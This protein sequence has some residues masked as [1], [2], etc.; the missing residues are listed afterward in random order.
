MKLLT[1]TFVLSAVI[2]GAFAL[3]G[4]A[5]SH[6][7]QTAGADADS[8]AVRS[9]ASVPLYHG[10]FNDFD[11]LSKKAAL[12]GDLLRYWAGAYTLADDRMDAMIAGKRQG[13]EKS[14]YVTALPAGMQ[15][16]APRALKEGEY[17]PALL[18]K[19]LSRSDMTPEEYEEKI[20]NDPRAAELDRKFSAVHKLDM[21]YVMNE[22]E[23]VADAMN[24]TMPWIWKFDT[25]E[26]EDL[27]MH[28]MWSAVATQIAAFT[29]GNSTDLSQS[30]RTY[31]GT[32]Y[33]FA[34]E[35]RG[36]ETPVNVIVFNDHQSTMVAG[37]WIPN[38]LIPH[39]RTF[40]TAH[41]HCTPEQIKTARENF[42]I[43]YDEG[44]EALKITNE[45]R[46]ANGLEPETVNEE[47]RMSALEKWLQF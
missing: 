10:M 22:C 26:H 15:D 29:Y 13:E 8:R 33:P 45:I 34:E 31:M 1:G 41:Y 37:G 17:P 19:F 25:P 14:F 42:I 35:M 24:D 40:R 2:T 12:N 20:Y 21:V 44:P 18:D 3:T 5:G 36:S 9:A 39:Y 4:C 46:T 7:S 6:V 32:D 16:L 38:S 11:S 43:Y 47:N 27:Y 30:D 28:R 23:L